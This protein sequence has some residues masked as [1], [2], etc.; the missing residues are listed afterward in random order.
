LSPSPPPVLYLCMLTNR[1]PGVQTVT[2][3][4]CCSDVTARLALYNSPQPVPGNDRRARQAAG[5]W[6]ALLIVVLPKSAG[7]SGRALVEHWKAKSRKIHCR[8]AFGVGMAR[9][10]GLSFL[11]DVEELQRDERIRAKDA[12][13][14]A[15]IVAKAADDPQHVQRLVAL[16][17]DPTAADASMATLD[18]LSFARR[19][20]PRRRYRRKRGASVD[21]AASSSG[22]AAAG[23]DKRRR[24][25]AADAK[26][27][28]PLAALLAEALRQKA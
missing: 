16:A 28:V 25:E 4:G 7:L 10:L 12:K 27:E 21:D 18:G 14:V 26:A 17:T 20:R 24:T 19:D 11:V 8:F 15:D 6:K 22:S 23:P 1:K 9:S 5:H 2:Q 3:L 13:L